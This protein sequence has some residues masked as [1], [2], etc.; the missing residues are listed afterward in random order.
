M[1]LKQSMVRNTRQAKLSRLGAA[2]AL[3]AAKQKLDPDAARAKK[4]KDL[5]KRFKEKIA[6]KYG[7]RGKMMALK[8]SSRSGGFVKTKK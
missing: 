5:W 2:M 8:A 7:A 3:S 4:F 6:K 1:G